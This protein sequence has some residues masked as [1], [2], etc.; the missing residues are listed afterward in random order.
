MT[1][2]IVRWGV[3]RAEAA[4]DPFDGHDVRGERRR[5][6]LAPLASLSMI[7]GNR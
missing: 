4:G 2:S 3:N 6:G 5:Q 7:K 1:V